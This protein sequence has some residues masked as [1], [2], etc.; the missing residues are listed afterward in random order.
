M[1]LLLKLLGKTNL[2]KLTA[3]VNG[4]KDLPAKLQQNLANA[5]QQLLDLADEERK[6]VVE[7][8]D[9]P[10][11]IDALVAAASSR[12]V[13]SEIYVSSRLAID[14]DSPI[15]VGSE[16]VSANANSLVPAVALEEVV[17]LP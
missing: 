16:L 1:T 15:V 13:A 6:T 9:H 10:V 14:A 2:E 7:E 3:R 11:D 12:A 8:L 17:A 4:L 5:K